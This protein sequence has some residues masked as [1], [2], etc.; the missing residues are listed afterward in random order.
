MLNLSIVGKSFIF[1]FK[2]LNYSQSKS[3]SRI[4][5]TELRNVSL[6]SEAEAAEKKKNRQ[7]ARDSEIV[8]TIATWFGWPVSSYNYISGIIRCSDACSALAPRLSA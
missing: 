3:D 4:T 1:I 2:L 5:V 7:L 6:S 8:D